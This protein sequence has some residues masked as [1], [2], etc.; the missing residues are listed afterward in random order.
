MPPPHGQTDQ[1]ETSHL[2]PPPEGQEDAQKKA[3][4]VSVSVS[5]HAFG[6]NASHLVIKA[7]LQDAVDL[8]L[9]FGLQFLDEKED[10]PPLSPVQSRQLHLQTLGQVGQRVEAARGLRE[11]RLT[12]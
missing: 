12:H 6:W 8:L 1:S 4:T 3:I 10:L 9:L 5:Q 2:A 7:L 11:E